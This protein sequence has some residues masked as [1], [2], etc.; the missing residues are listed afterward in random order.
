MVVFETS[1]GR[2]ERYSIPDLHI[3]GFPYQF[4]HSQLQYQASAV[5][6]LQ[7]MK[8]EAA[9]GQQAASG[10]SCSGRQLAADFRP[11][12]D[13][14]S[15]YRTPGVL[16]H[17]PRLESWSK[18]QRLHAQLSVQGSGGRTQTGA[19]CPPA[20]RWPAEALPSRRC[21]LGLARKR[22]CPC[23]P[24]YRLAAPLS[25]TTSVQPGRSCP[26]QP[27]GCTITIITVTTI[28]T[29]TAANQQRRHVS[30]RAAR[31]T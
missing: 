12:P 5:F 13:P 21:A 16:A 10:V 20:A 7:A 19:A 11:S 25:S 24:H 31:A 9:A 15:P 3:K 27:A 17:R 18:K 6:E 28:T 4:P 29:A 2:F 1:T 30:Q 14:I 23:A 22:C 26:R 8:Q